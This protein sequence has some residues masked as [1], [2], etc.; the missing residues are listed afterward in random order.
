MILSVSRE[1]YLIA[2]S[3]QET[4]K[5]FNPGS[6]VIDFVSVVG[7]S[8]AGSNEVTDANSSADN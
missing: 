6:E 1:T 2:S 8:E 5:F 3:S 7:P 4:F